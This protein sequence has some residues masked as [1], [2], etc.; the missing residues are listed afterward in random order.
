MDNTV[1]NVPLKDETLLVPSRPEAKCDNVTVARN[2][3]EME[4]TKTTTKVSCPGD[5]SVPE[6]N[7]GLHGKCDTSDDM[8]PLGIITVVCN[9]VNPSQPSLKDVHCLDETKGMAKLAAVENLEKSKSQLNKPNEQ[10]DR[11]LV[12]DLSE[13]CAQNE[14]EIEAERKS[15]E[16][17]P[18]DLTYY[19]NDAKWGDVMKE[20]KSQ[21][22]AG[23]Y[24]DVVLTVENSKIYAHSCVLAANSPHFNTQLGEPC[25]SE[26][27][28]AKMNHVIFPSNSK[29]IA[30][31]IIDYMYT[32]RLGLTSEWVGEI[33]S[34]AEKLGMGD[35]L[36]Y[37]GEHLVKELNI[38]NWLEVKSLALQY[39]LEPVTL[40]IKTFLVN[41]LP[42]VMCTTMFLELDKDD[43]IAI[44][45]DF[46]ENKSRRV[47]AKVFNAV[48]TWVCH[49]FEERKGVYS[50]MLILLR[51]ELLNVKSVS[52]MLGLARFQDTDIASCDVS[53][54]FIGKVSIRQEVQAIEMFDPKEDNETFVD[55]ADEE[56]KPYTD[57]KKRPRKL[58]P[59]QKLH[60]GEWYYPRKNKRGRPRKDELHAGSRKSRGRPKKYA[61]RG[62]NGSKANSS[63]PLKLQEKLELRDDSHGNGSVEENE[64]GG[65][66][67][68]SLTTADMDINIDTIQVNGAAPGEVVASLS[69]GKKSKFY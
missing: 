6:K 18:T 58:L 39:Q 9:Q 49:K 52:A 47:E 44:L 4:Y 34:V 50:E 33:M 40:S 14:T 54:E 27:S 41:H 29:K 21:T 64:V 15:N 20:L 59:P 36:Q 51:P 5:T 37:C 56:Y 16:Q 68:W 19:Q 24:C 35:I 61:S 66:N 11:V 28:A 13:K 42:E 8:L 32:S 62:N 38:N 7:D 65:F 55:E 46:N 31:C 12:G 3:N 57:S 30:E 1:D 43:V 25:I 60:R 63:K 26:L 17:K 53:V 69:P 67:N 2:T 48:L 22:Q 23:K 10:T 45:K